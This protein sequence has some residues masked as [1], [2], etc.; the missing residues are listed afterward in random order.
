MPEW[1]AMSDLI[2]T[3]PGGITVTEALAMD[4]PMLLYRPIP[5][6]EEGNARFVVETGAAYLAYDVRTA[7]RFI[8]SVVQSPSE[9]HRMRSRVQQHHVRGAADRI[10]VALH[11]LARGEKIVD[12]ALQV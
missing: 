12:T 3:K 2:V 8:D 5:G 6:Q 9:L 11:K 10:A 1:M 4:L 7:E